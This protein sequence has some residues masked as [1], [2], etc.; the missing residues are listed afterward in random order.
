M[1]I[2]ETCYRFLLSLELLETKLF[3]VVILALLV[4][5]NNLEYGKETEKETRDNTTLMALIIRN[6]VSAHMAKHHLADFSLHF[7][8]IFVF[9]AGISMAFGLFGNKVF[10]VILIDYFFEA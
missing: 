5:D 8:W 1:P 4:F 3:K 10:G 2:R 6:G 7:N 9:E